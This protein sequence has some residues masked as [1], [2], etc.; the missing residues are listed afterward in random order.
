MY[1]VPEVA[2]ELLQPSAH[3]IS[4]SLRME[5]AGLAKGKQGNVVNF[6]KDSRYTGRLSSDN[7]NP[8]YYY[9]TVTGQQKILQHFFFF[10]VLTAFIDCALNTTVAAT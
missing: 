1:F 4:H 6:P 10:T 9:P 8:F 3:C 5:V 2:P 7:N